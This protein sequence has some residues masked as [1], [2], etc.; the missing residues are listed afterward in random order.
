MQSKIYDTQDFQVSE[1]HMNGRCQGLFPTFPHEKGKSLGTRLICLLTFKAIHG[2]APSYLRELV[3]VNENHYRLRSSNQI[4]LCM[5]K[6]IT[7]KTLGDRV[8]A[9]AAPRIWNSL[10]EE[11]RTKS[12]INDFKRRLKAHFFAKAFSTP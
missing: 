11:L 9:V 7:K 10:P 12:D 5:P 6:G 3:V 8:F 2:S 1:G 4:M